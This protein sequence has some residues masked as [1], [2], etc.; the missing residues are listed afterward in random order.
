MELQIGDAI[1][2]PGH[3]QRLELPVARLP[4]QT[5]I[6]LPLEVIRGAED[7]PAAIDGTGNGRNF[8]EADTEKPEIGID[9]R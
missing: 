8:N 1:I 5:L 6:H 9:P 7:G 4:T 3:R 2:A